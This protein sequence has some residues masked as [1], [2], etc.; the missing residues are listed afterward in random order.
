VAL[1][2]RSPDANGFSY[3]YIRGAS[4]F[5]RS[6][7][8]SISHPRAFSFPC[9]PTED[10][11]NRDFPNRIPCRRPRVTPSARLALEP[12]NGEFVR[13]GMSATIPSSH[14]QTSINPVRFG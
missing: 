2:F 7:V 5:P 10:Q 12:P 11:E 3:V 4:T 14:G 1:P 8:G 9:P 6:V 13:P